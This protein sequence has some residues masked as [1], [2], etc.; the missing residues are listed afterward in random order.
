MEARYH[1]DNSA[2]VPAERRR[3]QGVPKDA[4]LELDEI[5]EILSAPESMSLLHIDRAPQNY[6]WN[7]ERITWV[8]F[9]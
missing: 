6:L 5:D 9:E 7:G 1:G 3:W 4:M 8:D 2:R